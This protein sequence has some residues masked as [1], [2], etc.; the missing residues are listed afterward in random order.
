ALHLCL[1]LEGRDDPA[2]LL[3]VDRRGGEG[4]RRPRA[5]RQVGGNGTWRIDIEARIVDAPPR[6][7]AAAELQARTETRAHRH[8]E[9]VVHARQLSI[10]V[11]LR[12]DAVDLSEPR[13]D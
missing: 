6:V 1:T 5:T 3:P 4:S 13:G 12:D 10:V 8:V 9:E 2:D 7:D 11:R